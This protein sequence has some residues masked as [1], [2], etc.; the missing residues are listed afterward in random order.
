M[1]FLVILKRFEVWLLLVTVMALLVF[2][3]RPES[4]TPEVISTGT[5]GPDE[6]PK[7]THPAETTS[8]DEPEVPSETVII[9]E[10]RVS[11]SAGGR[12]VETILAGHSPGEGDLVL[13]ESSVS[14]T[15]DGG[16]PVAR[17]FEPFREP[18]VLLASGESLATLRWWLSG[19][20]NTL[21]LEV[22][23]QRVRADLP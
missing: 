17:F 23:G 8:A 20:A 11:E 22:R 12:I 1:P 21:W 2:A 19:P 13:D 3:L 10:V 6:D 4:S 9:R 18:P 5:P 7:I 14:A 15:T 16:E